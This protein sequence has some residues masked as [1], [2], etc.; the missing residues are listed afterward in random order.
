MKTLPFLLG[1]LTL[2][3]PPVHR[4]H[5]A[6]PDQ[7]ILENIEWV[8]IWVTGANRND[9]PRVLLV[10]DSIVR[11]YYGV[12]E[13]ELGDRA[14][15]ARY[16]TSA[17]LT[18]PDYLAMLEILLKRYHFDVIHLNNGLHGWDYDSQA[19]AS[20]FP[21]LFDLLKRLAP[22]ARLI[23]AT[24]TP[25]RRKDDLTK[26]DAKLT[27]QVQERNRI[28]VAFMKKHGVPIDDLYSLVVDHPE[29]SRD[30]G[31][32]FNAAGYQV[33][34]KQVAKVI[35]EALAAKWK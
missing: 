26:L 18:N 27:R 25:V 32:H 6:T 11:G 14:Y 13:K 35:R 3:A 9:R 7:P 16:T 28:A 23:W 30:D 20:G 12:V 5:A 22:D 33:L 19:Y 10:G 24:T 29:Y 1:L 34:G 31:V 15:C 4:L 8:D 2:A 21:R 17:F